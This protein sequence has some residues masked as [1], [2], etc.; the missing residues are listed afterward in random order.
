MSEQATTS[1]HSGFVRQRA[2]ESVRAVGKAWWVVIVGALV[3]ALASCFFSL[4]Q[5]PMYESS[6]ILYVTSGSDGDSQAAYQG[7]LA[8]QQRVSSYAQLVHSEAV[9]ASALDASGLA[10]S[11]ADA[12]KELSSQASTGTVLLTI[13]AKDADPAVAA[14]LTN[15]I[16]K[17]MVDYVRELEQ[18]AGGGQPLAKLTVITPAVESNT[19][20]S[21]RVYRNTAIG[22]VLGAIVGVVV[23]LLMVRLDNRIESESSLVEVLD[24]P[25]F[26]VIPFDT[27]LSGGV[28][29]F[30][31]GGSSTTESF[32]RLRTNLAFADVDNP[33]RVLLVT[34]ANPNEGK[35]TIAIN[36]SAAL[37]EAG[38][39]VVLVDGDLRSPSVSS[40][41]SVS[42]AQGISTFL[43]G[44]AEVS[45]LLQQTTVP[46]LDVLSSGPRV[47]NPS[48]LLGSR[49]TR[50]MLSVLAKDYDF[51]IIDASPILPVSDAA[52]LARYTDGT[53]LTVGA[54]RC[55]KWALRGALSQL[56]L[57][58]INVLGAVLNMAATDRHRYGYGY[59]TY[60]I[61]GSSSRSDQFPG[62]VDASASLI[63]RQ[64]GS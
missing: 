19:A 49:K 30:S 53:L 36:V 59:G 50:D 33:A 8:S 15:A 4:S 58:N 62:D 26:G 24:E 31:T 6:A 61:Y 21:P 44:E 12:K 18:P 22:L 1:G 41:I 13:S 45:D 34:S 42:N 55:T 63:P 2:G 27:E 11:T 37:A 43:R 46:G 32:R 17:S 56:R 7:S 52:L 9:I 29:D 20:V 16:A 60:G 35:T 14:N 5:T 64:L 10:M 38:K 48:E 47:P 57:A 25:V 3:G 23:A 39:S 51:V 54:N 28:M 40:R